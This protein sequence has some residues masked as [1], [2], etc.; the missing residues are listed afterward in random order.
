MC[1]TL[2]A[3][4]D[5]S[6]QSIGRDSA[7]GHVM[8]GVVE[9]GTTED[10]LPGVVWCARRHICL[11]LASLVAA[12][13]FCLLCAHPSACRPH[14]SLL[15][16]RSLRWLNQTNT[17]PLLPSYIRTTAG[18]LLS[19]ILLRHPSASQP[20]TAT[21]SQRITQPSEAP[22]HS[23]ARRAHLWP[24]FPNLTSARMKFNKGQ[25]RSTRATHSRLV[26]RPVLQLDAS[27]RR[28]QP[29][30]TRRERLAPPLDQPSPVVASPV[31]RRSTTASSLSS[32][33]PAVP[34]RRVHLSPE[35]RPH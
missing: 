24:A 6:Q 1:A 9:P 7:R 18:R 20:L 28:L 26:R 11:R 31:P 19:C 32:T 10:N 5:D 4:V 14:F 27:S 25:R 22:L 2:A 23:S 3:S 34:L 33:I 35:C 16:L 21:E 17:G 30:L 12:Q 13:Y 29:H 15:C 8:R